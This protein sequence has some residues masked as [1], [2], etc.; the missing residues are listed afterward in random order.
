[1]N[2]PLV[3]D[4]F[5]NSAVGISVGNLSS[6]SCKVN[7][8]AGSFNFA[9]GLICLHNIKCEDISVVVILLQLECLKQSY[10]RWHDCHNQC[11]S[12]KRQQQFHIGKTV[13][14]IFF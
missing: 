8:C 2:K 13:S 4:T 5:N 10:H 12:H 9:A 7:S 14:C 6:V 11:C 3:F 1:S